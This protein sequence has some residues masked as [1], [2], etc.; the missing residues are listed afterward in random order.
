MNDVS[1]DDSPLSPLVKALASVL[2]L[3]AGLTGLI[4][5]VGLF[6]R[7]PLW[8]HQHIYPG[9]LAISSLCLFV[10]IPLSLLLACF[11]RTRGYAGVSIYCTSF[12]FGFGFWLSSLIVLGLLAS[13]FV[14]ITGLLFAGVGVIPLAILAALIRGDWSYL[15]Q[16]L[17]TGVGVFLI[18]ALGLFLVARAAA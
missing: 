3:V 15:W 12:V 8:L 18:R 9:V 5:I 16:L 6:S 1:S 4:S 17:A 13:R 2:L 7:G 11:R 10:V 14:I